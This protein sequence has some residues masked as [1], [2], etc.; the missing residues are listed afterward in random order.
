MAAVRD[1]E[2]VTRYIYTV[3]FRDDAA[4]RDDQHYEWLACFYID[5][6]TAAAALAWG[7]HLAHSY[8]ARNYGVLLNVFLRS[9]VTTKDDP[10]WEGVT[11]W[12]GP[13]VVDGQEATDDE[14]G[15]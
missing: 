1:H 2:A 7:D 11:V 13:V 15:W 14:I 6:E 8:V 5:A 3:W 4:D 9:D 12:D 10:I